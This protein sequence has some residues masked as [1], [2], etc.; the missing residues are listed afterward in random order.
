MQDLPLISIIVPVYNTGDYLIKCLDSVL[1][2]TY[3][4]I[5]VIIVDDG[6]TDC[7][8]EICDNFANNDKRCIV[9][10]KE[11]EGVS[12]ARNT[13]LK[14]AKGEYIGFV[15]SDDIIELDMYES[16]YK[17]MIE[18]EA[19]VSVCNQSKVT[20]EIRK[21]L[22]IGSDEIMVFDKAGAIKEV[23]YDRAFIGSPCNKLFKKDLISGIFF[24]ETIYFAEDKLFV[25]Q[26]LLNAK[27]I[28]FDLDSKY[29]YI[30][31]ENSAC[32][33]EFSEKTYTYH[34]AQER[35]IEIISNA[36]DD[37]LKECAYTSIMLCDIILLGMLCDKRKEQKDYCKKLQSSLRKNFK[38]SRIKDIKLR[39][40]IGILSACVSLNL[41]FYLTS[42]KGKIGE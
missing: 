30:V 18:Y 3:R 14:I 36:N 2:Q 32:T 22:Y 11:N 24:E 6:S 35:I 1:K 38:F 8:R 25:I 39:K 5:E 31:R 34:T 21:P 29:D 4:N 9:V 33:S 10:H 27:K 26:V 41:F 37:K 15:D 28:V 16:L 7:S 17:N 40:K 12:K 13:A 42:I 20:G 19:D 23:L